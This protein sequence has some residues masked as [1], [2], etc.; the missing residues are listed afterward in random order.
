MSLCTSSK[1]SKSKAHHFGDYKLVMT[2][3]G[4]RFFVTASLVARYDSSSSA[5]A[6]LLHGFRLSFE[7]GALIS[8]DQV[9]HILHLFHITVILFRFPM[10]GI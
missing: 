5:L 7:W 3:H 10:A 6:C 1:F 9:T 2:F 4:V 8:V